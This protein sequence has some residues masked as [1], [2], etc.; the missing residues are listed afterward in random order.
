MK[1]HLYLVFILLFVGICSADEQFSSA[2]LVS[3]PNTVFS[4]YPLDYVN[5]CPE[6]AS[7]MDS[8][9]VKLDSSTTISNPS[10]SHFKTTEDIQQLIA[11]K[12]PTGKSK[13]ESIVSPV[14][15]IIV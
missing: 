11:Q 15:R 3:L 2:D 5:E 10:V 4:T 1:G 13:L 9:L 12:T 14:D 7:A 8:Y 6:L